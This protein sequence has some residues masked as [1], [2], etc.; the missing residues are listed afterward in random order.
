MSA[1]VAPEDDVKTR[2]SAFLKSAEDG[3]IV[4][5][6][7]G[8]PAAAHLAAAD[9]EDVERLLLAHSTR[10]PAIL[11]TAERQIRDGQGIY[12]ADFWK[13]IEEEFP[14]EGK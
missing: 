1:K 3:P 11:Q 5:T 14:G 6:R 8:K 13:E 4:V 12:H 7:N 9:E 2:F 10:F